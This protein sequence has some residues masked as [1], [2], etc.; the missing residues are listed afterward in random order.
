M[1]LFATVALFAT[2]FTDQYALLG[3]GVCILVIAIISQRIR[4]ASGRILEQAG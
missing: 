1:F 3:V 2:L 4:H